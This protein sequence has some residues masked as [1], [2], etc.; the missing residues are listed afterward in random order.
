LPEIDTVKSLPSIRHERRI[1]PDFVPI[2][3]INDLTPPTSK[4]SRGSASSFSPDVQITPTTT[5]TSTRITPRP[6]P[7][8]TTSSSSRPRTPSR[9]TPRVSSLPLRKI[10]PRGEGY[11]TSYVPLT[12]RGF[13]T[14]AT[15][16]RPQG[17]RFYVVKRKRNP[18]SISVNRRNQEEEDNEVDVEPATS[19]VNYQTTKSFHREATL[20]S[21]ERHGEYGYIDPIGVRRVVTYSTGS[22]G[23]IHKGKENDYVGPNTYFEAN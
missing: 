18:N 9:Q 7:L 13:R 22:R 19:S 12:R 2:F 14:P 4:S 6:P 8:P 11:R 21:G 23:G 17:S 3:D 10:Q 1:A 15:P 16:R 5:A 20:D